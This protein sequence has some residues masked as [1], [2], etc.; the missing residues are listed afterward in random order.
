VRE[1]SGLISDA[2]KE[3][4]VSHVYERHVASQLRAYVTRG[5]YAY[6]IKSPRARDATGCFRQREFRVD[7]VRERQFEKCIPRVPLI[8]RD[9][10]R[11]AVFFNSSL[12][13]FSKQRDVIRFF[14]SVTY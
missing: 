9:L 2:Q 10:A 7:D 12:Y 11:F 13:F 3:Q 8:F 6:I 1:T 14:K 5:N 4:T